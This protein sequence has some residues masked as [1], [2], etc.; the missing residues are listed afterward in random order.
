MSVAQNFIRGDDAGQGY[1]LP[2]DVRDW[3]PARHLAWELAGLAQE[4]DLAPVHV[5]DRPRG[6]AGGMRVGAVPR[7]VAS[8]SG[9]AVLR[10]GWA[11][12]ADLGGPADGCGAWRTPA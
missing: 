8:R 12:P 1:L 9:W 5:V 2:P 4:M 6:R 3:L 10:S 7:R 11:G